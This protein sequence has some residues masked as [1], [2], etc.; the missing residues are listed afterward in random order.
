MSAEKSTAL[1][2]TA[3]ARAVA[4]TESTRTG[5]LMSPAV[6][7][8]EN[9]GELTLLA[10]MPGVPAS[11]LTVDIDE[12]VLTVTGHVDVPEGGHEVDVFREYGSG[13]FQRKFTLSEAIDQERIE[14]KLT[15]GVL[16]LALPKIERA[17]TRKIHVK[18]S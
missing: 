8:F 10:D 12:G 7:I 1:Q 5:V 6:D 13:T 2:T 15:D 14:A 18:T 4:E 16:R 3:D 11:N 9:Q 17:K